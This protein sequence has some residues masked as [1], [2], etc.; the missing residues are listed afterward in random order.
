MT[1]SIH[2]MEVDSSVA[3]FR[4]D[5]AALGR[6]VLAAIDQSH[7]HLHLAQALPERL[8]FLLPVAALRATARDERLEVLADAH[9]VTQRDDFRR[10]ARL[11]EH[12]LRELAAHFVDRGLGWAALVAL[13]GVAR[14]AIR[15]GRAHARGSPHPDPSHPIGLLDPAPHRDL[16]P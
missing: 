13:G 12:G 3:F 4:E 9:A 10:D 15:P 7:R 14:R 1:T 8:R 2:E 5:G 6:P 11:I 16:A